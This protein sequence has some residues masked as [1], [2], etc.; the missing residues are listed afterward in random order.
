MWNIPNKTATKG[1]AFNWNISGYV[2]ETNNDPITWYNLN[3]TLPKWI[4]FD[5]KTWKFT[6]TPTEN[7]EYNLSLTATDNDGTSWSDNFKITI[8]DIPTTETPPTMWDVPDKTVQVWE[9]F[10][11]DMK[12][13]ITKTDWDS[14]TC[15]L[16]WSVP[17][18]VSFDSSACTLSGTLSTAW[19]HD[20]SVTATDNDWI[21][22]SDSFRVT[23]EAVSNNPPTWENKT[24]DLPP[25]WVSSASTT[26]TLTDPDSGDTVEA[27]YVGSWVLFWDIVI[28]SASTSGN[29]IS[30]SVNQ[31]TWN[32]YI[33][34]KARDNHGVESIATYRVTFNNLD[35]N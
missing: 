13:Y 21:S 6:G 7:G 1:I 25:A 14:Y 29:T 12:S 35:W 33:D 5:S 8:N 19:A 32:W 11:I 28:S 26:V 34:Y 10:N 20:F 15:N 9:S 4:A 3:W 24:V 30:I 31:W 27:V 23:G 22:W 2:E 16:T 17:S 18:W